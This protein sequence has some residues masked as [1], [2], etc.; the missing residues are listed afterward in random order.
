MAQSKLRRVGGILKLIGHRGAAALAPENT[1]AAI[2]AGLAAGADGVEV[3]IRRTV[4]G[5][6]VLL[7]DAVLSATTDGEGSIG[8]VS[9]DR[10]RTL[11][12]GFRFSPDGSSH[13]FRGAGTRVPTLAEVLDC[14]P[15]DRLLILEIKGTPW[16]P[17]H[18]PSE[19]VARAVA[20][21]LIEHRD[22]ALTVSSFNPQ[23]LAIVKQRC[24]W[25]RT[26]VLTA[27]GFDALSNLHAAIEGGH[28][29]C[30]VP[31]AVLDEAFVSAA[32]EAG[33]AVV[34]WTV[35]DP[36]VLRAL[37]SMGVDATICDDPGAARRALA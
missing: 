21:L 3:D 6:L 22:R 29:E 2:E 9:L 28:E 24:L 18:D 11:D 30:H 31:V 20:D 27:R 33:R 13:P 12:A 10:V 36:A 1:I 4:D 19:P 32:H 7:H 5:A 17:G 14:V 26:G 37:S 16:E 15:S 34:A 23:A 35:D 25:L 8:G